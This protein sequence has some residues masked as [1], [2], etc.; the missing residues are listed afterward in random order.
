MNPQ[1]NFPKIPF[2]FAILFL[3]TFFLLSVFFF[4]IIMNNNKELASLENLWQTEAFKRQE[5][6]TLYDSVQ[7]I[8]QEKK[9]L[10]IHFVQSSDIVPLLDTI[11]GLALKT[12]SKAEITFVDILK[13]HAGLMVG[14]R[15]TGTFN[16]LYKFITLLE[17]APYELEIIS[18]EMHKGSISDTQDN[19]TKVPGWD[20]LL[21]VKLLSFI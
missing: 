18:M 16:G 1:N 3:G 17:N 19:E 7:K 5:L 2:F 14:V 10:E 20:M 9:E 4:R 15:A 13:D 11:E 8:E 12:N 6:K 21:K